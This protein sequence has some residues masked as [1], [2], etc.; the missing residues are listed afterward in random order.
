MF[1]RFRQPASEYVRLA[2]RTSLHCPGASLLPA[3]LT[4]PH[5]L[6]LCLTTRCNLSCFICRRENFKGT[7]VAFDDFV[8]LADAIRHAYV[9]DV[10]GWGEATTYPFFFEVV[11]FIIERNPKAM[12]RLTTN[13]TRLTPKIAHAL[14]GHIDRII[15]SLNAAREETY[16]AQVSYGRVTNHSF[17]KTLDA[18]RGFMA[19]LHTNDRERLTLHFVAHTGNFREI[20]EFVRMA[21]NLGITV[22]SVGNYMVSIPDHAKYVLLHVRDEYDRIIEQAL[23][24]AETKGISLYARTF[25]EPPPLPSS[26]CFEPFSSCYV[27]IGGDVSPCCFAGDHS[28][29]NVFSESFESVWFGNA[30]KALRRHRHLPQCRTCMVHIPFENLASHLSPFIIE[31]LDINAY[32]I[33]DT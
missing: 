5:F 8:K 17:E 28:M 19:D 29:G 24:E 11:E 10:T 1:Q 4:Y 22:V 7:D 16:Y 13:G 18:I 15:I 3:F 2:R 26:R 27:T 33:T 14:S 21:A 6:S 12:I 23:R 30:Y 32:S 25:S 31:N 9:I 20:P